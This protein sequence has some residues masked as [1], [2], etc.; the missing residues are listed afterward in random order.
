MHWSAEI[1]TRVYDPRKEGVTDRSTKRVNL[2]SLTKLL[3]RILQNSRK[4]GYLCFLLHAGIWKTEISL[5]ARSETTG[6]K[7]SCDIKTRKQVYLFFNQT[8][9]NKNNKWNILWFRQL[10]WIFQSWFKIVI[11]YKRYCT[12]T[13]ILF[14]MSR[15]IPREFSHFQLAISR[16]EKRYPIFYL[17]NFQIKISCRFYQANKQTSVIYTLIFN[18]T[19]RAFIRS[20]IDW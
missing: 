16:G 20:L 7:T 1:Q 2:R 18:F 19:F 12:G 14:L 8:H 17:S 5:P 11:T 15:P 6:D 3:F 4:N 13:Y 10:L 9:R